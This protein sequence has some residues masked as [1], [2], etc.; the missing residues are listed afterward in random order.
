MVWS[1]FDIKKARE[2]LEERRLAT[3]G[4]SHDYKAKRREL[5]ELAKQSQGQKKQKVASNLPKK[6]S[7]VSQNNAK[8]FLPEGG[9]IWRG[10][11]TGQWCGHLPP[12][13][14]VSCKWSERGEE[15]ALKEVLR[16]L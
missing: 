3:E 1:F 15:G 11:T 14:R 7:Q 13:R 16:R 8:Q 4:F 9:S 10:L 12:F 6:V 2:Q 5:Y